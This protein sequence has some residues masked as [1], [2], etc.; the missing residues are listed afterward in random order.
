VKLL[1]RY[2]FTE[3]QLSLGSS[4]GKGV[5]I[6]HLLEEGR[7]ERAW[8]EGHLAEKTPTP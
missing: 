8:D 2:I 4:E 1:Q 5:W 3:A 7:K 6:K